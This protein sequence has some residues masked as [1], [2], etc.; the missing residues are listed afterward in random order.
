MPRR[1]V[2]SERRS[3]LI[4][5]RD[6]FTRVENGFQCPDI[7]CKFHS[8]PMD[9]KY[10]EKMQAHYQKEHTRGGKVELL[11]REE[12]CPSVLG[13]YECWA[14][15]PRYHQEITC[16][17]SACDTKKRSDLMLDHL[18][19]SHAIPLPV[20]HGRDAQFYEDCD[21]ITRTWEET[22]NVQGFDYHFYERRRGLIF[23]PAEHG[24][25]N[26]ESSTA[27]ISQEDQDISAAANEAPS[28]SATETPVPA[29]A[30]STVVSTSTGKTRGPPQALRDFL[31]DLFN[32]PNELRKTD[33]YQTFNKSFFLGS[34]VN[35][36]LFRSYI[37]GYNNSPS[38][39]CFMLAS[40]IMW[41]G[42][43]DLSTTLTECLDRQ[44][45]VAKN[46]GDDDRSFL[47]YRSKSNN[48]FYDFLYGLY[49]KTRIDPEHDWPSRPGS[50]KLAQLVYDLAG[51][52]EQ[53]GMYGYD[54]KTKDMVALVDERNID[55]A[56][57]VNSVWTDALEEWL[58]HYGE[59]QHRTFGEYLGEIV[60][61]EV[62]RIKLEK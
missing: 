40:S 35:K 41:L 8:K 13:S 21:T 37:P 47:K 10:P 2:S 58:K 19:T 48:A 61:R 6:S 44:L 31:S 24:G 26:D 23:D 38:Y 4:K 36:K 15:H 57:L 18:R 59:P 62:K 28:I 25:N 16:P 14:C 39:N 17:V 32:R 45:E 53:E 30:S 27:D 46:Y 56:E 20:E 55:R 34:F 50:E 54:L 60:E 51:S 43:V 1:T 5:E 9:T 7:G 42:N 29:L 22:H 3:E 11:C 49:V 52:E 12:G 33:L